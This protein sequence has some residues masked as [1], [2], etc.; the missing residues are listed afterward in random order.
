MILSISGGLDCVVESDVIPRFGEIIEAND[1]ERYRVRDV[2]YKITGYG[3]CSMHK[4]Y[5]IYVEE[6]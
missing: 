4:I 5:Y 6:V 3:S 2:I 1:G